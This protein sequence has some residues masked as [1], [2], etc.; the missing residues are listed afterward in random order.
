MHAAEFFVGIAEVGQEAR[1]AGEI[2]IAL[3]VANPQHF[4]EVGV[5]VDEIDGVAESSDGLVAD[6]LGAD[7]SLGGRG[8]AFAGK[9]RSLGRS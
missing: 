8:V 9:R 4:L 7:F 3:V 6:V 5:R 2:E 1:H